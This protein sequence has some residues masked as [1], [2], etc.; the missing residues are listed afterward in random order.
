MSLYDPDRYNPRTSASDRIRETNGVVLASS[1]GGAG[2]FPVITTLF[3]EPITVVSTTIDTRSICNANIWLNFTSIINI[4]LGALIT[5][6]FQINRTRDDR[7][8]IGVGSTYTFSTLATAL[9]AESFAFQFVDRNLAPGIYT[10]EIALSTNSIIDVT[11]GLTI[12]N[13][14]LTALAVCSDRF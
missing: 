14:T 11:P 12:N 1:T 10:Y 3:A 4:P 5:L 13:A 6:N 2:P 9:E 7:S 8:T